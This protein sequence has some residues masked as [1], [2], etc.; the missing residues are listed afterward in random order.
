MSFL[1][2]DAAMMSALTEDMKSSFEKRG[3]VVKFAPQ[4]KV[5]NHPAISFL[6]VSRRMLSNT[7]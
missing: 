5:L 4:W 7:D 1:L 2:S 6:V 3:K